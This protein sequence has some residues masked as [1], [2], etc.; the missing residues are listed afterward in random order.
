MAQAAE[1]L[2]QFGASQVAFVDVAGG[3]YALGL[4]KKLGSQLFASDAIQ[5]RI[6][7]PHFYVG[8]RVGGRRRAVHYADLKPE[9]FMQGFL[10]MLHAGK[11]KF[12]REGMLELLR[13]LMQDAS[14]LGW[15]TARDL[16]ESLGL[17][18]ERGGGGGG[19]CTLGI[20]LSS[21]SCA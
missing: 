16:Y 18:F 11:N 13:M 20:P 19:I 8:C 21:R 9:E 3:N 17:D 6:D 10:S 5:V 1:K 2:S 7:W 14:D 4:G 15:E 12:D